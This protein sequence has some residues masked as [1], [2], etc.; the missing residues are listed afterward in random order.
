VHKLITFGIKD[1]YIILPID[2]LVQT[3]KVWLHVNNNP[4]IVIQKIAELVSTVLHQNYFQFYEKYC[5]PATGIAIVSPSSS[6]MPED[7]LH[8]LEEIFVKHW[9]ETNDITSI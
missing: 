3:T 8:C 9:L 2:D 6:I 1:L 7:Y 5:N 4:E